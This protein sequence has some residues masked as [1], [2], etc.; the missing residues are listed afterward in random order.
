MHDDVV[1]Q[2]ALVVTGV[3]GFVAILRWSL[4]R[5]LGIACLLGLPAAVW[6]IWQ[7]GDLGL[8]ER[9]LP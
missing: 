7:R 3:L 2:L 9:L 5:V 8:F 6:Y 4:A 1:I